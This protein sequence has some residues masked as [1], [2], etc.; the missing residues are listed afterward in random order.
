[1]INRMNFLQDL[2]ASV[3]NRDAIN[4]PDNDARTLEELCDALLSERG[5][6]SGSRIASLILSRFNNADEQDQLAFFTMLID[7]FDIDTAAVQSAAQSLDKHNNSKNLAYLLNCVEP[8]R[9]ELFRRL[10]RIPGATG[11]LVNMRRKLLVH[12]R[13]HKEL[14]RI[15]IDFQKLFRSW[16]NRGFLVLREIDWQTPANIL[17][18]LIEYEA[19]HA[20]NSWDALRRRLA[21]SD[22]KCFAFFHPSMPDEPLIFVEVALTESAPQS[23]REILTEEREC[24]HAELSVR[25]CR[26]I[27]R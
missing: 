21:P 7:R 19:V 15:D 25:T 27:V 26:R 24:I 2:L 23:I 8:K 22:R 6:V 9:Q 14:S 18:K 5:E 16:F 11:S 4:R 13:E 10:N 20:I 3:L 12:M 17:E 1:M